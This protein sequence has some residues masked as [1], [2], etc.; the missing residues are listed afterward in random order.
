MASDLLRGGARVAVPLYLE[1]AVL[2][3]GQELVPRVHMENGVEA[4]RRPR[5]LLELLH[6]E[7]RIKVTSRS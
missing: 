7:P 5:V 4:R 6:L 3:A 1:V 2:L